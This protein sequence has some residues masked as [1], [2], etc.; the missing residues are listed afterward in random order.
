MILAD[1]IESVPRFYAMSGVDQILVVAWHLHTSKKIEAFDGEMLRRSFRS[2][3]VE[4]PDL[5]VY[6]PRMAA[7]R[8]PQ[9][10][11]TRAG[12]RIAGSVLRKLDATYGKN[13]TAVAVSQ[14]LS[15]LPDKLPDL[16][17]QVFLKEALSCYRI[18]AFRAS[19]VMAWNLAY[20]H[21]R[22]WVMADAARLNSFNAALAAKGTKK[23]A[24]AKLEDFDDL[25]ESDVIELCR[26]S[27]IIGKNVVD[28]LRKEIGRRNRV[29]HP[30]LVTVTQHQAD[31]A[32]SDLVNNVVLSL[33]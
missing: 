33:S 6:L 19:I 3:H 4:P 23:G 11:K 22:R 25:K 28:I 8:P 27:K 16:N 32:I 9:L 2:I 20:D 10:L 17:E 5:S 31:D 26:S 14:I 15:T 7:K 29:A 18:G 12:Y 30:S 21:L 13:P 24:I 1:L